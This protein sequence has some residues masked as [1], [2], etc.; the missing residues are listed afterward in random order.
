MTTS[1]ASIA[2]ASTTSTARGQLVAYM[3]VS[4]L[5]QD[6]ARQAA[7]IDALHPDRV[8]EDHCSGRDTHR[9]ALQ[10][11]M[12]YLREGDTLVVHSIDRLCRNT[13]DLLS[14]V[15]DFRARGIVVR[16]L[17]EGIDT[18]DANPM[19]AFLLTIIG[20]VA[21]F[22]RALIRERQREGIAIAKA[23]GVY[24]GRKPSLNG[25]QK[26]EIRRLHDGGET[27]AALARTYS[28]SRNLIY[29]ALRG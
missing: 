15:Q 13:G 20:A 25:E 10:A 26:A 8:F 27:V 22:E 1:T 19:N 17:K 16:F 24:K 3:R 5:D 18:S 21:E 11:C 23:N 29:N 28:V 2:A 4:T 6:T 12:G 14:L 9:P 7:A